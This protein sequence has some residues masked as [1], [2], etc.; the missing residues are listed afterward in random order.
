MGTLFFTMIFYHTC[1]SLQNISLI[2]FFKDDQLSHF[3]Y[4][5][6]FC[7]AKYGKKK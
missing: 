5:A 3:I 4:K 6:R 7:Y 2:F 1:Y